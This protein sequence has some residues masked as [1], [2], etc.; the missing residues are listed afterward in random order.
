MINI[1]LLIQ[2]L[3]ILLEN[4][5]LTPEILT[6]LNVEIWKDDN[7]FVYIAFFN[8][9]RLKWKQSIFV[10]SILRNTNAAKTKVDTLK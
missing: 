2:L 8:G 6:S 10:L 5:K 1:F 3:P 9:P 7:G 4:K